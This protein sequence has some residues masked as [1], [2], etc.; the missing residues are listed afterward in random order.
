MESKDVCQ[1]RGHLL[2]KCR[3]EEDAPG[4]DI[5]INEGHSVP[6]G[7]AVAIRFNT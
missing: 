3:V 1:A 6:D 5:L 7:E 2:G 4:K